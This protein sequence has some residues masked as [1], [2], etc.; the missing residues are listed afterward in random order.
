MLVVPAGDELVA[1]DLSD[2]PPSAEPA[3]DLTRELALDRLSTR[4]RP[5]RLGGRGR[6][7]SASSTAAPSVHS[8]ELLGCAEAGADM[9]VEYAKEREQFGRPIGSFQAVKHRCADMLVDVEGMRSAVYHAAWALGAGDPDAIV[10]ASTAKIVVLRRR[11]AGGQSALQVHGGIGFTWE[12]DLHLLP[13]AGP[14]RP[15]QLRRRHLPPRPPR[16]APP[17]PPRRRS[18]DHLIPPLVLVTGRRC[19]RRR[20]VTKSAEGFGSVGVAVA[21]LAGDDQ[22]LDL[23]GAL[24]DDHQRRVAVVALDVVLLRVPVAAVDAER[25]GGDLEG[26]L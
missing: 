2:V 16:P 13:Q 15:G 3:M 4:R 20:P 22:L 21:E 5:R 10:A 24:A 12:H 6:R 17:R 7:S 9:A 26:G 18:V 1:V 19:F 8:A 11:A 25:V 23:A 14:A